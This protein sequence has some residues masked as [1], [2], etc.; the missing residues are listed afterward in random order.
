[1]SSA[2][3]DAHRHDAH[4]TRHTHPPEEHLDPWHMHT[5]DEGVPQEEHAARANPLVLFIVFIAIVGSV[6][7]MVG[8]LIIYYGKYKTDLR[9]RHVETLAMGVEAKASKS[10]AQGELSGPYRWIGPEQD[11][12]RIPIDQAIEKTVEAYSG[13][14][15]EGR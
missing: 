11:A 7:A 3:H 4:D 8:V 12:V 15:I 2:N 10:T 9:V 13:R 14:A 6:V 5:P 1:M